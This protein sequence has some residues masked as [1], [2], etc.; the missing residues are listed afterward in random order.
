MRTTW[1]SPTPPMTQRPSWALTKSDSASE[2][3]TPRKQQ[4]QTVWQATLFET[5]LISCQRFFTD[6]FNLSLSSSTMIPV[7]KQSAAWMTTDLWHSPPYMPNVWRD[8]SWNRLETSYQFPLT[9]TS[10]HTERTDR[11][12]IAAVL[13][14]ASEHLDKKNIRKNALHW[15]Q[16]CSMNSSTIK[17]PWD[18]TTHYATGYSD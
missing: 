2:T 10:L 4:E 17:R 18:L 12:Q 6:I 7:S 11:Q 16:S 3:S 13:H 1:C 9:R 14:T 15:L 5:V 8:W